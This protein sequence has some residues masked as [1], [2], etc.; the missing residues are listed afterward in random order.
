MSVH[1]VFAV[2]DTCVG[3]FLMPWYFQNAA[4]AVRAL[5]DAVNKPGED[6][7][8]FQHPEHYQLYDLGTYDDENGQF[9]LN[10]APV[11][12]VDCQSLVRS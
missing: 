9:V 3:T 5:G 8:F 4:A 1:A 2:R 6:N 12:V 11:F 7:Q 10:P